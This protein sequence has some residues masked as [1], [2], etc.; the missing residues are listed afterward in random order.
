MH[1]KS[2]IKMMN[3]Q[4]QVKILHWQTTSYA[5]HNAY[6]FIYDSLDDLIDTFTETCMGKYGRIELT[7]DI[8]E[9]KLKNMKD[10]SINSYI[11]EFCEF[12]TD[13]TNEFDA[14]KDTDILNIR[15]EILGAV[16]KLKYLLTL[17]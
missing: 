8:S 11:N 5:R 9:L 1:H 17:K 4:Q 3:F 7:D 10:I 6:G 14:E 2:V 13:L 12:L 16:N 15:D